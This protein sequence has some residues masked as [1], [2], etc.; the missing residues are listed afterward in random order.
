[1]P[2]RDTQNRAN[3]LRYFHLSIPCSSLLLAAD[4]PARNYISYPYQAHVH[5][6]IAPRTASQRQE[7]RW[8][9]NQPAH[10]TVYLQA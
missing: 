5:Q 10:L 9:R 7:G 3:A 2:N 8:Q 1:M 6:H 4:L